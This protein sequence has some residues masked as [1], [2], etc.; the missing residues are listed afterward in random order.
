MGPK[1]YVLDRGPYPR[2]ER[3]LLRGDIKT[4]MWPFAKLLCL[5]VCSLDA[6]SGVLA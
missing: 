6:V 3:A 5:F 2:Q 1:N 4:A